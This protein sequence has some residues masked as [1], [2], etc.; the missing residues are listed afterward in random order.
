LTKEE[1]YIASLREI[2]SRLEK[3][4]EI[5]GDLGN[6]AA[7]LKKRLG[8]YWV[9]F[10]FVNG[11]TLVLGPFQGTPACVFLP[12]GEGVCGTCA[13]KKTTVLVPDVSAFA[14]HIACDPLSKSEIAV[15]VFGPDGNLQAVLDADSENSNA[16]DETDKRNLEN[17]AR[18]LASCWSD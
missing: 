6:A 8:F 11:N 17:I 5:I 3:G 18:L 1:Q 14:G 12:F 15:P 13:M 10:Y 16:F 9:G 7:V 4:G 2:E